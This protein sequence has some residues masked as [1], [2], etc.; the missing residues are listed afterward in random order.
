VSNSFR[1]SSVRPR[2]FT[3]VLFIPD[4][5][6]NRTKVKGLGRT[7][8]VLK[9]FDTD[10]REAPTNWPMED[11]GV[12]PFIAEDRRQYKDLEKRKM[13]GEGI[14]VEKVEER[15]NPLLG[16]AL[17]V[18]SETPLSASDPQDEER[19]KVCEFGA[20]GC[21][22]FPHN[23]RD[24]ERLCPACKVIYLKARARGMPASGR[25]G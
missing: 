20:P 13:A 16:P 25:H 15:L 11:G 8:D 18:F 3:L 1:T 5:E 22:G 23:A 12:L 6:E 19:P 9:L 21:P 24:D 4:T 2:P 17:D 10:G 7:E 14:R